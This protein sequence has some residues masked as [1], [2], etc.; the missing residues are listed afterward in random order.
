[1]REVRT[2]LESGG[3][4]SWRPL[5]CAVPLEAFLNRTRKPAATFLAWLAAAALSACLTLH[6]GT[7]AA[8]QTAGTD[9][10]AEAR[11]LF[12]E[13]LQ[14]VE[15]QRWADAADRFGRVLAIRSSAIVSYNYAS[16]L[17]KLD[18]LVEASR[19][20]R[21]VIA[22][23]SASPEVV[24]AARALLEGVEP[25]IGQLTVRLRGDASNVVVTLDDEPLPEG[26][27]GIAVPVDPGQRV[28]RVTRDGLPIAR[29]V[30]NVMEGAPLHNLTI[31]VV[32]MPTEVAGTSPNGPNGDPT[33]V[34]TT[35]TSDSAGGTP[36][37]WIIGGSVVAV[38]V[39]VVVGVLI[40]TPSD[41]DPVRGNTDPAVVRGR[42]ALTQY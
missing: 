27:I 14:F 18:R 37:G 21:G 22:D 34:A 35:D 2:H 9:A 3:R 7:V 26:S 41:P 17:V 16:A 25:R 15:A 13:G 28:V 6:P 24:E 40:A 4:A 11:A 29:R 10:T 23:P 1:V 39:A 42:V 5:P 31:D 38:G 19:A 8:Q 30:V 33:H 12:E 20:L 32:P 36:W